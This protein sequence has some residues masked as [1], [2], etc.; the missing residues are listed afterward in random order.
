MVLS[1]VSVCSLSFISFSFNNMKLFWCFGV[2][3]LWKW[4]WSVHHAHT[5]T[6]PATLTLSHLQSCLYYRL[7]RLMVITLIDLSSGIRVMGYQT[8]NPITMQIKVS[9]ADW[10]KSCFI[11]SFSCLWWKKPHREIQLLAQTALILS[12]SNRVLGKATGKGQAVSNS[13]QPVLRKHGRLLWN[14]TSLARTLSSN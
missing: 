9:W 5:Y 13:K 7:G 3:W 6:H 12:S 1:H 14:N 8:R 4:L 10:C 11:P 2:I